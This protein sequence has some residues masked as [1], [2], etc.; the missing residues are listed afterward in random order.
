MGLE[1]SHFYSLEDQDDSNP[2]KVVLPSQK[3]T[4]PKDVEKDDFS[5]NEPSVKDSDILNYVEFTSKNN[6]NIRE[7]ML[8]LIKSITREF[9]AY[10]T[11]TTYEKNGYRRGPRYSELMYEKISQ[12]KFLSNIEE[13]YPN[14]F[15]KVS[16]SK[17]RD[18]IVKMENSNYNKKEVIRFLVFINLMA[19]DF[20]RKHIP[21]VPKVETLTNNTQQKVSTTTALEP[22]SQHPFDLDIPSFLGAK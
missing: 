22:A 21:L 1:D 2:A 11:R 12:G 19:P 8:P 17:A 16:K 4:H 6:L 13:R 15:T 18:S 7:G 10:K 5:A 9:S 3:I 14:A 20:L